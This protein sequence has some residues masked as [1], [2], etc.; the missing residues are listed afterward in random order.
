MNNLYP[1][2]LFWPSSLD[3]NLKL[4]Y[5]LKKSSGNNKI[6]KAQISKLPIRLQYHPEFDKFDTQN[7]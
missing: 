4:D 3:K 6:P 7:S 1:S 5:L 2:F